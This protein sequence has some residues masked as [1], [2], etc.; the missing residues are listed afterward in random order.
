MAAIAGD[1]FL[2]ICMNF[3]SELLHSHDLDAVNGGFV[4]WEYN[5]IDRNTVKCHFN[6]LIQYGYLIIRQFL[7]N[8]EIRLPTC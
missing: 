5:G 4:G 3:E 7:R 2:N 6:G 8:L 1:G